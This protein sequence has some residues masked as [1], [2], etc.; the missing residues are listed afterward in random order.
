MIN[1]DLF[2]VI[3]L[4]I[5]S[6][7]GKV[8]IFFYKLVN[9]DFDEVCSLLGKAKTFI[10]KMINPD[11]NEVFRFVILSLICK[12]RTFI[13]KLKVANAKKLVLYWTKLPSL[14]NH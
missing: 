13:S 3:S 2:T 4:V 11:L 12:A 6:L 10:A 14:I 9:P 7:L 1:S 8:K 5:W